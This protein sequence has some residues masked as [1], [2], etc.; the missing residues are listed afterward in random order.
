MPPKF[1]DAL[2]GATPI[3]PALPLIHTTTSVDFEYEIGLNA[4]LK[5]QTC[6]VYAEDLIYFFYGKPSYRPQAGDTLHRANMKQ[7]APVCLVLDVPSIAT[8]KRVMPF[9]S[10]AYHKGLMAIEGHAHPRLKKEYFEMQGRDAPGG[11]VNVF[12]GSNLHYYDEIALEK[13]RPDPRAN[14]CVETYVSLIS[15]TGTNQSDSRANSIE[16]QFGND[17][18]LNLSGTVLAVAMAEPLYQDRPELQKTL[19]SWKAEPLLYDLNPRFSANECCYI[20]NA[21]VRKFLKNRGY[22]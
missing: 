2:N 19:Q 22:F 21:E 11:I 12:F 7:F 3:L 9:D 14:T 13:P 1:I 6:K 17:I 16:V 15:R 18:D 8:P 20:I 4:I 5:A 10:G